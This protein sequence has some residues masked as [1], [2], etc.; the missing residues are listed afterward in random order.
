MSLADFGE[1]RSKVKATMKRSWEDLDGDILLS[2]Y[3][4]L[5]VTDIIL[6]ASLC[7]SFWY[8]VSKEPSLWR[9]VDLSCFDFIEEKDVSPGPFIRLVVT[10]SQGSITSITFPL[11]A[12]SDDLLVVA[13]RC[14]GLRH[15]DI[16]NPS[17]YLM[18][19]A[20]LGTAISK[21]K[22]LEGMAIGD[23]FISDGFALENIIPFC[24]KFTKLKVY[25]MSWSTMWQISR[26]MPQIDVLDIS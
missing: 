1:G 3:A 26:V 10:R 5:C 7:C 6:G 12:S 13:E 20:A 15:F 17:S 11:D 4:R 19:N 25:D 16:K 14:P 9:D 21:L 8:K 2:I 23:H 24:P 18:N 22:E